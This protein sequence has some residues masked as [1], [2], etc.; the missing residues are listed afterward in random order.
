MKIFASSSNLHR[1]GFATIGC[2]G[3]AFIVLA[4]IFTSI[5]L[6]ILPPRVKEVTRVVEPAIEG[7]VARGDGDEF[8]LLLLGP[9]EPGNQSLR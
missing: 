5:I 7:P 3:V 1:Q 2:L 6:G 9:C 4:I 8:L